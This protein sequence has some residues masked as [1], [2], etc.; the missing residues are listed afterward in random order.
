M[1]VDSAQEEY[2]E[3]NMKITQ[4]KFDVEQGVEINNFYI[5]G[6][7]HKYTQW[8]KTFISPVFLEA[9]VL[10]FL[11]EWGDRSQITT[12]ILAATKVHSFYIIDFI[13]I[14]DI[15]YCNVLKF[16]I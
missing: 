11:A 4:P 12:I 1:S 3:V 16:K 13:Y 7:L 6:R 8:I 2:N 5:P 15:H 9:F 14:L 10:T